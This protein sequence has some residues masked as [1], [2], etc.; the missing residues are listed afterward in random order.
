MG[1]SAV[2]HG[3]VQ[4][5]GF[6]YFAKTRADNLGLNGWVCNLGDGTVEIMAVGNPS[7]LERFLQEVNRGPLGSWVEK[8]DF[9][10]IEEPS[11]YTGFNIKG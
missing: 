4:G 11:S 6:R 3:Q 10:W 9:Q 8:V 5:V 1:L 7:D 2:V